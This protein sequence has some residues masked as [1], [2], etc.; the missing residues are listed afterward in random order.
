MTVE[1]VARYLT[2]KNVIDYRPT[3]VGGD[4]FVGSIPDSPDL[5]ATFWPGASPEASPKHGYRYVAV[6][7][8]LRSTQG[9]PMTGHALGASIYN[10]LHGL[11]NTTLPD[12]TYVVDCRGVQSDPARMGPDQNNRMEYSINFLLEIRSETEHSTE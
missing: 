10:H 7:V 3:A 12:D 1:G 4:A 2:D 11:S 8:W 9:Q 5:V 6:Q